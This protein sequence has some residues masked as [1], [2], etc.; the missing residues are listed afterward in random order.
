MNKYIGRSLKTG[1][2]VEA[3]NVLYDKTTGAYYLIDNIFDCG[4]IDFE[5]RRS[6]YK[7]RIDPKSLGAAIGRDA[8]GKTIYI[9]DIVTITYYCQRTVGKQQKLTIRATVKYDV[10]KK[11]SY[12]LADNGD[13]FLFAG[14]ARHLISKIERTGRKW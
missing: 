5:K 10:D 12:M 14:D 2:W 9:G 8:V 13:A 3:D 6:L 7:Y 1:N 4:T 11:I